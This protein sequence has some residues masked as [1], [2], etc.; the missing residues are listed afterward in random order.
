MPADS[1]DILKL[2]EKVWEAV[3]KLDGFNARLD[4]FEKRFDGLDR[5]L[6]RADES[7]KEMYERFDQHNS[8][9]GDLRRLLETQI[10]DIRHAIDA[11]IA[12]LTLA[13]KAISQTLEVVERVENY[14]RDTKR[15]WSFLSWSGSRFGGV[16]KWLFISGAVAAAA[17]AER[18]VAM[19]WPPPGQ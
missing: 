4:G 6:D 12:R 9:V 19:I 17:L 5:R 1:G 8:H 13:E 16:L 3:G 15:A 7:R 2:A 10:T 18:I 14:E 11:V